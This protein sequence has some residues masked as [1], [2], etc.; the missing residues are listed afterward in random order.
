MLVI[1]KKKPLD[2]RDVTP[3]LSKMEETPVKE[4]IK[5]IV[6]N[7]SLANLLQKQRKACTC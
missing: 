4:L 7:P 5:Q 2:M 1:R 6:N 3:N